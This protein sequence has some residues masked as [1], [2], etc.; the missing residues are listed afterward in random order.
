MA[1]KLKEEF[2][3]VTITN[4]R[5]PL[6][7]LKPH[8]IKGLGQHILDKYFEEDKPIKKIKPKK[9]DLEIKD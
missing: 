1:W 9:D 6:D 3:G 7:N 5:R 4:F 8:H 2:K